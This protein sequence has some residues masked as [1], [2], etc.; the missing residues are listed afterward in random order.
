[1]NYQTLRWAGIL[2]P[3]LMVGVFETIRHEYLERFLSGMVGN[4]ATAAIAMAITFWF[5][6]RLFRAVE[7]INQDLAIEQR[8]TALLE[9]RD[10]IAREMHDGVSQSLFF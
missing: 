10:R 4:I 1:M 9:E 5:F 8:R 3:A 6:D 7:R 2:F